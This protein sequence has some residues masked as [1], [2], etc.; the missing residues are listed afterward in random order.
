M[1]GRVVLDGHSTNASEMQHNG[2]EGIKKNIYYVMPL[3]QVRPCFFAR[4][5]SQVE[6][7]LARYL[8]PRSGEQLLAQS[9]QPFRQNAA[10]LS[11]LKSRVDQYLAR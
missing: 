1:N 11:G 8:L 2:M 6:L 10:G 3:G 4:C 9:G 7:I 5:K